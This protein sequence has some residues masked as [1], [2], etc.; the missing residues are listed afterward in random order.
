MMLKR[1]GIIGFGSIAQELLG[2]LA[3]TLE[4]PLDGIVL[5]VRPGTENG[6]LGL[7]ESTATGTAREF[8]CVGT[9]GDLVSAEPDLVIE[10]AGHQA[11][12]DNAQEVLSSG[13][14]LVIASTGALNDPS[15]CQRLQDAAREAGSQL[16]I[17]AGA[18]GGID[19]LAGMRHADISE[20]TYT[21]RKPPAS[22]KGTPAEDTIDLSALNEAAVFYEGSARQ[23][24]ADYPKNANTAA[25][26]ALAGAGFDDTRVRLIADPD[27][28][29]NI[30]QIEV[31]SSAATVSIRVEGKPSPANPKTS[32]PTVYSLVREVIRRT[33]P[34]A[35]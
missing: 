14:D 21:S 30:H 32:L 23:A 35:I 33:A 8:D 25:T 18:V 12:I 4:E 28:T 29:A 24:S 15:L 11:V 1:L 2:V 16:T 17:P 31:T 7:L 20:V 26:I 19:I 3:S 6:R 27:V 13:I 9:I 22:W 10:C 34:V 5:L